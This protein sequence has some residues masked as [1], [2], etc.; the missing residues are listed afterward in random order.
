MATRFELPTLG[1]IKRKVY[2]LIKKGQN[3]RD[4]AK[5][6]F[7][8]DAVVRRFNPSQISQIKAKSK[9]KS[10]T[11]NLDPDKAKVFKLFKGLTPT[12][13]LIQTVLS[14]EFVNKAHQEFLEFENQVTISRWFDESINE[15]AIEVDECNNLNDVYRALKKTVESHHELQEEDSN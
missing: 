7:V 13:I 2:E 10:G 11:N 14:F 6:E 5:T 9:A 8:V 4:I 3:Y 15:L 12:D 1:S